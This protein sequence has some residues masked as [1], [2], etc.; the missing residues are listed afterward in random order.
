MWRE[1]DPAYYADQVGPLT[2]DDELY[3]EGRLALTHEA[4]YGGVY[5]GWFNSRAKRN[6]SEPD[7]YEIN[8]LHVFHP[9]T[10]PSRRHHPLSPDAPPAKPQRSLLAIAIDEIGRA[11]V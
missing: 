3:A 9:D 5:L 4:G 7:T 8:P 10:D 11:H 6:K 2:L 1:K